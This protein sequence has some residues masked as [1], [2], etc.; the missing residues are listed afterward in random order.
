MTSSAMKIAEM[1]I[2]QNRLPPGMKVAYEIDQMARNR[3][4]EKNE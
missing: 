3:L 4:T 2:D 1:M